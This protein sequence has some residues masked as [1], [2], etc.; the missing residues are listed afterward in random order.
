MELQTARR[1]FARRYYRWALDGCRREIVEDF[2]RL[3]S[4]TGSMA[5]RALAFFESLAAGERLPAGTA[6]V[7]R[8]HIEGMDL[9]GDYL[10]SADQAWIE[11]WRVDASKECRLETRERKR[12]MRRPFATV[13]IGQLVRMLG[14]ELERQSGTTVQLRTAVGLWTLETTVGVGSRPFYFQQVHA[15]RYVAIGGDSVLPR[16]GLTGQTVWDLIGAG[17]EERAASALVAAC[18]EFAHALPSMLDGLS[19]DV[20][21]SAGPRRVEQSAPRLVKRGDE[22]IVE[23]VK[24]KRSLAPRPLRPR[25]A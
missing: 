11:R 18:L 12:P 13:V 8:F 1:E 9:C 21:A 23:S 7:K 20:P 14:G 10:T 22:G 19:H 24:P 17:E 25:R 6:L 2:P 4:I 15:R 16:L 5:L 3:R